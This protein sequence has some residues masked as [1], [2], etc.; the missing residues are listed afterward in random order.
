[1]CGNRLNCWNTIPR[2]LRTL[3]MSQSGSVTSSPI[4]TTR[5]ELGSSNMF[6]QRNN[7]DFPEPEGPITQTTS[8]RWMTVEMPLSTST[9]PKDLCRST[10]STTTSPGPAV[11]GVVVSVTASDIVFTD[12]SWRGLP[13]AARGKSA[14]A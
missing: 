1:M 6:T 11:G 2:L 9:E 4:T 5:P 13:A 8:P 14:A 7:V 12:L 3:S 10:T